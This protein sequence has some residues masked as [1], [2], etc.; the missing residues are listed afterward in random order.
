MDFKTRISIEQ[1]ELKDQGIMI[2]TCANNCVPKF[3]ILMPVHNE[4]DSITNV[5]TDVYNKLSENPLF[6][7]EIILAEDGSNDN[8]KQVI[9]ELSKKIPLKAILSYKR[10][11]YAGGIKEGLKVVSSPYVL[12]S[13][14][15]GQH[16]PEDF[17][18]LKKKLDELEHPDNVIVS[19]NRMTRADPF[20]RQIISKTFQILNGIMFDLSPMEDITSAFKLNEYQT[21]EKY[22]F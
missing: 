10:K 5:V 3:S 1:Q 14:S 18:K 17:W 15:D 21:G 9:I 11:G 22:C 19:G 7:F 13:D 2:N 8:T 6:A 20:H 4:D 16:K 12:V